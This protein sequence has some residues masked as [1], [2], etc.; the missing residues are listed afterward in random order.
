MFEPTVAILAPALDELESTAN[1]MCLRSADLPNG[2]KFLV[3]HGKM[4]VGDPV[5]ALNAAA[6]YPSEPAHLQTL[7]AWAAVQTRT[8]P[9][10]RDGH[11]IYCMRRLLDRQKSFDY[12]L[13]L[14]DGADLGMRWVESRS[15]ADA[16]LLTTFAGE[17]SGINLL[18]KTSDARS[19][20]LLDCLWSLYLSGAVYAISPY[21]LD[22]AVE[23]AKDAHR[24]SSVATSMQS[25]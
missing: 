6:N 18:L 24:L 23:A 1:L 7:A 25:P 10:F 11:A 3:T 15:E 21:S 13:L 16:Q 8:D 9:R 12:L 2:K 22:A 17:A 5:Q 14:R 19:M 20:E 4:D